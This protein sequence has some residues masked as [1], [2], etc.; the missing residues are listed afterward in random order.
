MLN[1]IESNVADD[2]EMDSEQSKSEGGKVG[3]EIHVFAPATVANVVCDSM[4]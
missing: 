4:F 1:N 3:T 2:L